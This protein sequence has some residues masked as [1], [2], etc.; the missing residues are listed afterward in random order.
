[1]VQ[2]QE[3]N[4]LQVDVFHAISDPTRRGLLDLVAH[5]EQPVKTFGTGICHVT[6]RDFTASAH[7]Q[8]SGFG[9]GT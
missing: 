6:T 9:R 2:K 7:S 8:A 5:G 4:L 1:M 3:D